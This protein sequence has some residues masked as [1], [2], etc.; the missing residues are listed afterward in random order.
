M[1]VARH[2]SDGPPPGL[3]LPLYIK[4][5]GAVDKATSPPPPW[6]RLIL[7][8]RLSHLLQDPWGVLVFSVGQLAALI[9]VYDILFAG[10]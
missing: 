7:D 8:A 10:D 4:P 6:W 5:L 1:D 3:P 9:D 2:R